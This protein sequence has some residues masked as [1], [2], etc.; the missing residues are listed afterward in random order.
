MSGR[1][2]RLRFSCV[3][4]SLSPEFG[5]AYYWLVRGALGVEVLRLKQFPESVRGPM[6]FERELVFLGVEASKPGVI[7]VSTG[8]PS[9]PC[10]AAIGAGAFRWEFKSDWLLISLSRRGQERL[11]F[12]FPRFLCS[13]I[14]RCAGSQ[15]RRAFYARP[16]WCCG[17]DHSG[18]LGTGF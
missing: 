8:S 7:G 14:R 17:L 18:R 16:R 5:E 13:D 2:V 9:K 6:G 12:S 11:S 15:A 4:L 1:T 10:Y 3:L